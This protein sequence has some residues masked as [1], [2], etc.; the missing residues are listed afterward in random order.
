MKFLKNKKQLIITILILIFGVAFSTVIIGSK[1]SVKKRSRKQV[2]PKV[3]V[4]KTTPKDY[5]VIVKGYGTVTPL[6]EIDIVSEVSGKI[7]SVSENFLDGGSF[8]KNDILVKINTEDYELSLSS[9]SAKVK[10][11]ETKYALA[12]EESY[13]AIEEWYQVHGKKNKRKIPP[14]VSKELQLAVADANHKANLSEYKKIKLLLGRCVIRAPFNGIVSMRKFDSGQYISKGQTIGTIFSTDSTQIILSLKDEDLFWLDVPGFTNE[15]KGSK[16]I[17]LSKVAGYNKTWNGIISRAHGKI[18]INT[19]LVKISV[20]VEKPY[21]SYPPLAAGLFVKVN[22]E[23]KL[24]KNVYQIPSE[25]LR[26]E[27]IIWVI[28]KKNNLKFRNVNIIKK[29]DNIIIIDKG[30]NDGDMVVTSNLKIVANGM[31]VNKIIRK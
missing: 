19:R 2:F 22:I 1:K 3:F 7:V 26:D 14:L 16:A 20:R 30:I 11:S 23:G 25:A 10:D 4:F 31:K 28:D 6:H 8:N 27:N 5:R 18:D 13:I 21:S 9:A 17:I 12:K 29:I 24:L 15:K